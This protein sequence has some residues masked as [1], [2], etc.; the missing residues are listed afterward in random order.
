MLKERVADIGERMKNIT[1]LLFDFDGTLMDT[2][3][4]IVESWQQVYKEIT[5]SEGD[6]EIILATFGTI[7][8]EALEEA[9]PGEPVEKLVNIYRSYHYDHFLELIE[10]YPG[11][12]DMLDRAKDE[13]YRM[14][15][16]TSRLKK[17]AML[18]V[19]EFGLDEY[20]EVIITADDCTG[21]KPDPEPINITL[22]KMGERPENAVMVGDTLLDRHCAKN[23]GAGSVLVS[24][25]PSINVHELEGEDVPDFIL[26]EPGDLFEFV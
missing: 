3:N 13:G 9:F 5:G 11:I 4:V 15:L 26:E 21:H 24:W 2:T 17:T 16:V 18:A 22:E 12:R 23:A 8:G 6:E 20:F 19:E 7:L 25:A 14:A 10:L 1:T